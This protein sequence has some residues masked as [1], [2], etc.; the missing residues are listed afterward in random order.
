MEPSPHSKTTSPHHYSL[1]NLQDNTSTL[2]VAEP[3]ALSRMGLPDP[4]LPVGE[5]SQAGVNR[6]QWRCRP[7]TTCSPHKVYCT[8]T[9]PSPNSGTIS[10]HC[11]CSTCMHT[12]TSHLDQWGQL[13]H[14]CGAPNDP[15][16]FSSW[17]LPCWQSDNSIWNMAPLVLTGM[18]CGLLSSLAL[19][20]PMI[21][22]TCNAYWCMETSGLTLQV[23]MAP[24]TILGSH[25]LE[26]HMPP[27]SME[28]FTLT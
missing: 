15:G 22:S 24:R 21:L 19:M 8:Y 6:C 4:A 23:E 13:P 14:Y 26:P 25:E 3:P 7:H 16:E 2:Q 1:A 27:L 20:G 28:P 18:Q 5:P 12:E 11:K 10:P 9:R 17:W